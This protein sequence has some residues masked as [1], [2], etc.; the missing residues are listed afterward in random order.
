MTST[1][2]ISARFTAKDREEADAIRA[3]LEEPAVRAFV[4][5]I[6][7]LSKLDSDRARKRVL[8]FVIDAFDEQDAG[9]KLKIERRA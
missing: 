8:S 5:V 7:I 3:G 4:T 6:G 9:F 1:K 2:S